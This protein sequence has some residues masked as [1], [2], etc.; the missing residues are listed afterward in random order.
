MQRAGEPFP[1]ETPELAS[2]RRLLRN[3]RREACVVLAVWGLLLLWVVGYSYLRG[4]SHA[5]GSPAMR[6]N[7]AAPRDAESFRTVLGLPDW[8]VL[9]IGIP[10][11]A[12]T[13]FTVAFAFL[14]LRDDELPP[15]EA[16]EG[17]E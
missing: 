3:A 15:P 2:R 1:E 13:A 14:G 17:A 12:A 10:W 11:L 7:L 16:G 6:W 5:A 8:V 4:Y 9:G